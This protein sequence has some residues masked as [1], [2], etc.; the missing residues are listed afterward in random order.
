MNSTPADSKAPRI[1]KSLALV[2]VVRFSFQLGS[3]N[4]GD[5]YGG[6][7]G[8]IVRGPTNERTSRSY[9]SLLLD[10]AGGQVVLSGGGKIALSSS[11]NNF[12]S[13]GT[14]VTLT[15]VNNNIFGAGGIGV[16]G[17]T[18]LTL[19]NSGTINANVNTTSGL[20]VIDLLNPVSNAGVLEATNSG[21]LYLLARRFPIPRLV[22][23]SPP[24]PR[25][26]S[27]SSARRSLAARSKPPAR[28]RPS[29]LTRTASTTAS[30]APP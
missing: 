26:R 28:A 30:A 10:P 20:L 18:S 15:N 24:A 11:G 22:G 2:R 12:F 17:D 5:A 14:T 4:S 6:R 16:G 8:K 19:V 27:S 9:L 7:S 21:G 1:A 3:T 13:V 25:P 29:L 23:S